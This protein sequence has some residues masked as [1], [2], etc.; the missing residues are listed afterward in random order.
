MCCNI[1]F[2]TY[3]L[4]LAP[5]SIHLVTGWCTHHGISFRKVA[6]VRS[7]LGRPIDPISKRSMLGLSKR[8]ALCP[9]SQRS[10]ANHEI[11]D[12]D[13]VHESV[14][15]VDKGHVVPTL[16]LN[17]D[18]SNN[19]AELVSES[20]EK[21]EWRGLEVVSPR[22]VLL[23]EI[24]S[25]AAKGLQYSASFASVVSAPSAYRNQATMGTRIG[26]D[27]HTADRAHLLH[28]APLRP[29]PMEGTVIASDGKF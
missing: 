12:T 21:S 20:R 2:T 3:S 14:L 17:M 29:T 10:D 28:G 18:H 26:R 6:Q 23:W 13:V 7:K 15:I 22:V 8:P 1:F 19:R 16:T 27:D 25:T 24:N 9:P 11:A 5:L 4:V